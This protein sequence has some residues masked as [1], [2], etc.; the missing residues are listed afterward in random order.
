M[1]FAQA[2]KLHAALDRAGVANQLITIRG[3]MHG[4][5]SWQ[6]LI[7][8]FGAIKTFLNKNNVF[9]TKTRNP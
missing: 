8:S 5:F 3:L 4:G 6:E 1:P 7:D 2:V 9:E